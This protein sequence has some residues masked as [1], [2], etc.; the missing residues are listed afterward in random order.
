MIAINFNNI[1]N[2]F[3]VAMY[4]YVLALVINSERLFKSLI[5]VFIKELILWFLFFNNKSDKLE[6]SFLT[7]LSSFEVNNN[8]FFIILF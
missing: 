3:I 7:N 5:F 6:V 2:S 8:Q 4:T 1:C